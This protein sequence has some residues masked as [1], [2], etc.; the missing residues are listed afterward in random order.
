MKHANFDHFLD[1]KIKKR[2]EENG[3]VFLNAL[4]HNFHIFGQSS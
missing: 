3:K 2:P 4:R 1:N